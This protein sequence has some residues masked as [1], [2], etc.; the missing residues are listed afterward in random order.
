MPRARRRGPVTCAT[1]AWATADQT[2]HFLA[3]VE[4]GRLP[5]V[6]YYKPQGNLNMHAG[7]SDIEDGDRH[8]AHVVEAL[9]NGPQWRR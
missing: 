9:Q 6:T 5:P 8:I 1:R 3:D 2:N 4:A 7:Y